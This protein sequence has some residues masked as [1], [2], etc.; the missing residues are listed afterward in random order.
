MPNNVNWSIE[1]HRNGRSH[2]HSGTRDTLRHAPPAR[3][4]RLP[5]AGGAVAPRNPHG[6][7]A[8]PAEHNGRPSC[9]A[10]GKDLFKTE[11]NH[12]GTSTIA[13]TPLQVLSP[14]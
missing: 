4:R 3:G 11:Q 12:K 9:R 14:S 8:V 6:Q 13:T 7:V 2:R 1:T 10:R 5:A